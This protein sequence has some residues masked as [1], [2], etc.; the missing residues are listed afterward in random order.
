MTRKSK[1]LYSKIFK[2]RNIE[3]IAK[4]DVSE[5]KPKGL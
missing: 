1:V 5:L 2:M 3:L 4:S